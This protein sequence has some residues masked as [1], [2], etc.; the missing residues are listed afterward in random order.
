MGRGIRDGLVAMVFG[1]IGGIVAA[2]LLAPKRRQPGPPQEPARQ[3]VADMLLDAAQAAVERA[4]AMWRG[5]GLAPTDS[6]L[7]PD[8]RISARIQSELQR[9]GIGPRLLDITTVEGTVYLRGREADPARIDT[10]VATA[11]GVPG[12]VSVVDEMRRD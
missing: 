3:P 4:Q 12:V 10:I 6:G 5:A 8:E 1:V 11:R 2:V 9:L 7:L